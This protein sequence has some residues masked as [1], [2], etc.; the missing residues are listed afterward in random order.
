MT[1]TKTLPETIKAKKADYDLATLRSESNA[2]KLAKGMLTG[3]MPDGYR[4]HGPAAVCIPWHWALK[5]S[6][7]G[8]PIL[9]VRHTGTHGEGE[10]VHPYCHFIGGV[11]NAAG[12]P[13]CVFIWDKHAD[14]VV[15]QAVGIQGDAVVLTTVPGLT[16]VHFK[17]V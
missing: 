14:A 2:F 16:P 12:Q 13:M 10:T 8:N 7:V 3:D 4:F 9:H 5:P 1:K 15:G 17:N 11:D 6:L